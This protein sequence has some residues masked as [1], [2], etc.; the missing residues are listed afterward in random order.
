[1]AEQ[2]YLSHNAATIKSSGENEAEIENTKSYLNK[3]T[4]DFNRLHNFLA[5]EKKFKLQNLLNF[6]A[7]N[8]DSHPLNIQP[9]EFRILAQVSPNRNAAAEKETFNKLVRMF[10]V[11]DI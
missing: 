4:V 10:D 8:S 7:K 3:Y 11:E 9:A 5:E 6:F 1:M 2:R